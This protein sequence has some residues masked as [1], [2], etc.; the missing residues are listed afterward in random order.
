MIS[1]GLPGEGRRSKCTISK[2]TW[3]TTHMGHDID[4]D[5][6]TVYNRCPRCGAETEV[7][8]F[9]ELLGDGQIE[10]V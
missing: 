6:L 9:W 8:V 4:I 1:R 5:T 10:T 7:D 2:T 3:A